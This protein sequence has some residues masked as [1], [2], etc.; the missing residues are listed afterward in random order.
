[1][2]RCFLR[3]SLR[4]N[5]LCT[6]LLLRNESSSHSGRT[7]HSRNLLSFHHTLTLDRPLTPGRGGEDD[8][9]QASS[10]AATGGKAPAFWHIR[11]ICEAKT[12][13]CVGLSAAR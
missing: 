11:N 12:V 2:H 3:S 13:P 1:M 10:A 4:M 7:S 8:Q 5:T 9:K 6:R